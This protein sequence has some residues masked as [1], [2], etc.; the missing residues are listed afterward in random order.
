[1]N[2]MLVNERNSVALSRDT[3][4]S[5][6]QV[7]SMYAT[8]LMTEIYHLIQPGGKHTLCGLRISRV[9]S[10]RKANTLQLVSELSTKSTICKH[11]ER[12]DG[13]DLKE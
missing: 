4:N 7:N 10:E 6:R 12:I 5:V 1:M 3:G 2:A 13:Q 8:R 11:C 9:I